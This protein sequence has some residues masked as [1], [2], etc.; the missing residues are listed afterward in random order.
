MTIRKA[1]KN[2][3]EAIWNIFQQVISTG[4]T[5]VFNPDTPKQDLEKHWFAPNMHTYVA[6]ENGVVSGTYI[7]KSNQI[8]LGS[9][10]ANCSYM[11]NPEIRGRGIGQLL[12]EH[13]IQ[14]AK[15]KGYRGIQ[16]NIVVSTNKAALHLWQ[17]NGFSIIGTTPGGFKHQSEGYVD[18]HIMFRNL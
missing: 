7:L 8:D 9:H 13:S 10:I 16:F 12:C 1:V 2:D 11:V 6:E 4:D 17:K 18:A 5:Y 15:E 3:Y 14:T